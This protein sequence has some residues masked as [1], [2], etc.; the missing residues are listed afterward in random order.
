M[1]NSHVSLPDGIFLVVHFKWGFPIDGGTPKWMV[2][3]MENP[4]LTWDD[5]GVPLFQVKT[6][7]FLTDKILIESAKLRALANFIIDISNQ[8]LGV[9]SQQT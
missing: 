9:I 8:F 5:F 4:N 2:F 6:K 1:F 3:A 7:C